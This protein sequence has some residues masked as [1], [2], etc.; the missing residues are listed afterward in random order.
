MSVCSATAGRAPQVPKFTD[1]QFFSLSFIL[2][3]IFVVTLSIFLVMASLLLVDGFQSMFFYHTANYRVTLTKERTTASE[4]DN[5]S[6][7]SLLS[8]MMG[9]PDSLPENLETIFGENDYRS[10]TNTLKQN[11]R[12]T[13]PPIPI[14]LIKPSPTTKNGIVLVI[15]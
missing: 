1:I 2:L 11:L 12:I 5:D 9:G 13:K 10:Q 8:D 7:I 4:F 6:N 15:Y 14:L 3:A